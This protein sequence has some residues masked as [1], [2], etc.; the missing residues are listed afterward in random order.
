M[1]K[2]ATTT[3]NNSSNKRG[4]CEDDEHQPQHYL[5]TP[6]PCPSLIPREYSMTAE[7]TQ[8]HQTPTKRH[9]TYTVPPITKEEQIQQISE[10][11]CAKYYEQDPYYLRRI[12]DLELKKLGLVP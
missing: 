12:I 9:Q 1:L 6:S 2:S 4:R 5:P 3:A 7:E 8:Y 10:D 11:L